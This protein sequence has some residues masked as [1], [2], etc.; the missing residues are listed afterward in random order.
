MPSVKARNTKSAAEKRLDEKKK[1]KK[2]T[3]SPKRPKNVCFKKKKK[4]KSPTRPKRPK[5]A[6]TTDV[7]SE[8]RGK[9][10]ARWYALLRIV[11]MQDPVE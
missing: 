7:I 8:K 6:R 5:N 11:A 2:S 1:K 9:R 4:K 3:P 10:H